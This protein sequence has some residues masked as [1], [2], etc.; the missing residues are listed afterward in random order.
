MECNFK[1]GDMENLT[2]NTETD[3]TLTGSFNILLNNGYEES[4]NSSESK[5][6]YTINYT[7]LRW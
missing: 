6:S 1:E 7:V 3:V 2:F 4:F 5:S